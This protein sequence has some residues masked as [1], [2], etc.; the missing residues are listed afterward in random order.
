M[1]ERTRR[2]QR[3]GRAGR[4]GRAALLAL[5]VLA[6]FAIAPAPEASAAS[7]AVSARWVD[8]GGGRSTLSIVPTGYAQVVGLSA[9][10]GVWNNAL[11]MVPFRPYS[12]AV[13][14]SLYIQ[15]QCHLVFRLKT[16]YNLDTWRPAV[17]LATAI[18]KKCNP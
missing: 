3:V 15:L 5:L 18:A 8:H 1:M 6:T 14:N 4:V 11:S 10:S 7:Y 9:A 12:P 16:P 2:T 17:P 13:F